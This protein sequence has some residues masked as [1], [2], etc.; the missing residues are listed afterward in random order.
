[1]KNL[2]LPI[3]IKLLVGKNAQNL[4]RRIITFIGGYLL[5]GAVSLS[6]VGIDPALGEL[7]ELGDLGSNPTVGQIFQLMAGFL[8]VYVSRLMSWMRARKYDALAEWIGPLIGRSLP[9]LI[10]AGF[11]VI[12]GGL[13][14]IGFDGQIGADTPL[15]VVVGAVVTWAIAAGLSAFE[16][17]RRNLVG[18][19]PPKHFPAFASFATDPNQPPSYDQRRKPIEKMMQTAIKKRD[20]KTVS[21]C[22]VKLQKLEKEFE[23]AGL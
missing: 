16:D 6:A 13:A 11:G 5:S 21:E 8:L 1:M 2:I 3:L 7:P 9:Q 20:N 12:S 4:I 22:L 14:R 15:A 19:S 23:A 10:G 18:T 17:G